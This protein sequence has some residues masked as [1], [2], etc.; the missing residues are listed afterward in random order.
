MA[1]RLSRKRV[2]IVL[3][4]LVTAGAVVAGYYYF[5][6]GPVVPE[7]KELRPFVQGRPPV[8]VVFT[9]RTEPASSGQL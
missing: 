4:T 2:L 5:F 9:S 1:L 6:T 8:P 7:A 3:G